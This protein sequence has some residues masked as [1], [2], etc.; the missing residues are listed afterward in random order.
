MLEQLLGHGESA[1]ARFAGALA[2][3]A[4]PRLG[5]RHGAAARAR[6]G[7]LLRRRLGGDARPR[8][9]RAGRRAGA[10]RRRLI[11]GAA[12]TLALAEYHVSDI[13]EARALLDEAATRLD[14]LDDD[15]LAGNLDAALMTGWA[16]QCLARW[17]DVHRHY[18][19][20]LTVGR[21]TGQGYLLVPMTIGRSI[22]HAWQGHLG[23]A[24][25][26]AEEAVEAAQLSGNDQSL[27]WSLTLRTWIATR[28]GDLELA[29]AVGAE[30]VEIA[31]GLADTHWSGLAGCYL[32]EARLEAGRTRAP[33]SS[34]PPAVPTSR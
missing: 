15:A 24:A 7:A 34:A 31:A 14:A 26:L 23:P 20:A 11:A 25:E 28:S 16:E 9:R 1:H 32:A 30:A 4:G 22:A 21:A 29:L 3:A 17:D 12:G 8:R 5:D 10:R 13:A 6:Q 19:R 33:T 2:A 18:E 27:A